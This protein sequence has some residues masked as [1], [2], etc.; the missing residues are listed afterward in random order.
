M[1]VDYVERDGG[2]V[3]VCAC[4]R[5]ADL[6]SADIASARLAFA[7]HLRADMAHRQMAAAS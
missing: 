5:I 4:G 1:R 3:W 2:W 6:P 7:A